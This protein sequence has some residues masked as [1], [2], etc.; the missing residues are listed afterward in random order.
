MAAFLY[1]AA[2][3]QSYQQHTVLING[4]LLQISEWSIQHYYNED[5][6]N[7][8]NGQPTTNVPSKNWVS[9]KLL[10]DN[11]YKP[12]F[13]FIRHCLKSIPKNGA[14]SLFQIE[15]LQYDGCLNT[16]CLVLKK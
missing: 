15:V 6:F 3:V 5:K 12:P 13:L 2:T 9:A 1:A 11:Q 10:N 4:P 14:Q 8:K 16:T 7:N